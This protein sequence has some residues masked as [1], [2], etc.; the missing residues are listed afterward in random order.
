MN[1]DKIN[2]FLLKEIGSNEI[3]EYLLAFLVV[4]AIV[5]ITFLIRT[6]FVY[7]L[8]KIVTKSFS[9]LDDLIL[10][11]FDVLNWPLASIIG[12]N[13]AIRAL[14]IPQSYLNIINVASS[15]LILFFGIRLINNIV[16]YFANKMII[17]L[18]SQK[19]ESD[20]A[21]LK[22]ISNFLGVVIW[23]IGG[24]MILENV[25]Y[26]VSTLVAGVGVSSIAIAFA[27]QN[28]LSDIFASVSIFFD[29][30]FKVGDFIKVDED[31][32]TVQKIGIKSSRIKTLDGEELVLPNQTITKSKIR[33]YVDLKKRRHLFSIGVTYE[34]PNT[35][36]KK[37]PTII[38]KLIETNK[39]TEFD[40]V[41]FKKYSDFALEFEISYYV[42]K[43][44]YKEFLDVV[45]EINIGIKEAFEKEK[46]DF[47][48]P[49]HVTYNKKNA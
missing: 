14:T 10:K 31:S 16:N 23:I 15:I 17:K 44:S 30:P 7:R 45:Q 5:L 2:E 9:D 39:F 12:F 35:K 46:I 49:T 18:D 4:V 24:I 47:A 13:L 6:I 48:Y 27:L 19:R 34:T 42:N 32:G 43:K 22:I 36:L 1:I 28:I 37:I 25:G 26:D 40:R 38:Q 21:V 41:H 8:R 29:K 33:N 3:R 20:S 11:A